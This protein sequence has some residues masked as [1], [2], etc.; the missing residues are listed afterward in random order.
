MSSE[1]LIDG[2][3]N[4]EWENNRYE[5]RGENDTLVLRP[6]TG[7]SSMIRLAIWSVFQAPP[8]MKKLQTTAKRHGLKLKI[9]WLSS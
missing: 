8:G 2:V 5:L 4:L 3:V 6:L 7:F 1:L 9:K